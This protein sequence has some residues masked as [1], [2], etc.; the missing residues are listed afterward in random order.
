M[1]SA[2]DVSEYSKFRIKPCQQYK[3]EL[4][5]VGITYR[6]LCMGFLAMMAKRAGC[7]DGYSV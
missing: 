4:D 6:G 2:E 7:W 1:G 3:L 5:F